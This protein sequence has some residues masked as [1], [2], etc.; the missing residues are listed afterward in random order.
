MRPLQFFVGNEVIAQASQSQAAPFIKAAARDLKA[1]RDSKNYRPIPVGYSAADIAELRPMLQDYLT[2]GD[3][4]SDT[5]DFFSLNSYEWCGSV[6]ISRSLE[7][8]LVAWHRFAVTNQTLQ[9]SFNTSGYSNLEDEA[10]SF[11]VPI[12]FSET[13]CN[14]V[15]PRTFED[16]SAIFGSDMVN[17]WSG[18]II[19]EWIQETNNY[20][21]ISYGP[22]VDATAPGS[23]IL[24]GFTR[25]G[26]PTPVAPDFSNLQ[27]QWKTLTPTGIQ[28]SD[29][30]LASLSTRACPASTAG[31]WLV[32]A[33]MGLPSVG[34]TLYG[35]SYVT[36]APTGSYTGS[37]T[38]SVSGSSF[39][40]SS[41]TSGSNSAVSP[42]S[43]VTRTSAG[44]VGVVLIFTMWL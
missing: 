21:L 39:S 5:V 35:S 33:D 26:T 23:G 32:A 34:E 18:A 6:R 9:S 15:P 40:P 19:Y 30:D 10:V 44:L 27:A 24:A 4:A 2:C 11:P 25:T 16:Q 17:D 29:M 13:G 38:G 22:P 1:Y 42:S 8:G 28:S 36:S 7:L 41:T 37:S 3:N 14:T 12:F 31:G 43:S 20:G